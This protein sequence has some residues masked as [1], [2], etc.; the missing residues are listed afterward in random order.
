MIF[1]SRTCMFS[2]CV[3]NKNHIFSH[4][5]CVIALISLLFY[6]FRSTQRRVYGYGGFAV[7]I[8]FFLLPAN[9]FAWVN[10]MSKMKNTYFSDANAAFATVDGTNINHLDFTC[11]S[12]HDYC[13]MLQ[14]KSLYLRTAF[15]FSFEATF[16]LSRCAGMFGID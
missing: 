16:F 6:L 12:W 1:C 4:V 5:K 10:W 2:C 15:T 13:F 11:F 14:C 8:E 7:L 9:T 3:M